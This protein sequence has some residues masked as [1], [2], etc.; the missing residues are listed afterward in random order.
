MELNEKELKIIYS[1][2]TICI[3]A[4]DNKKHKLKNDIIALN[5]MNSLCEKLEDYFKKGV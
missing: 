2:L 3:E 4:V 1:L 5:Q